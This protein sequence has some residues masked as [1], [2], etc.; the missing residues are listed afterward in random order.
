M[1]KIISNN[2]LEEKEAT[3]EGHYDPLSKNEILNLFNKEEAMCKI[4]IKKV[5]NN[6]PEIMNLGFFLKINNNQIP[7]LNCLIINNHVIDE[8]DIEMKKRN[9]IIY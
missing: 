5:I 1:N 7:F 8:K 2:N 9:Y 6:K 4:K 3:L